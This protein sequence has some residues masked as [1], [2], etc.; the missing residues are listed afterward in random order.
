MLSLFYKFY[1]VLFVR[2][3]KNVFLCVAWYFL[4]N[5]YKLLYNI[6]VKSAFLIK[7]LLLLLYHE[8]VSFYVTEAT[9][10]QWW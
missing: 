4:N 8:R 7:V 3:I 9:A 10:N 1:Y 2:F 6:F 5:I